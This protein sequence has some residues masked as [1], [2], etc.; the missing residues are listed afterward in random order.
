MG[1]EAGK[2]V[3]TVYQ[4]GSYVSIPYVGKEVAIKALY[5]NKGA[6]HVSIPIIKE[7]KRRQSSKRS[8]DIWVRKLLWS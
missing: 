2:D 7:R 1:K 6:V 5:A 3:K 4:V 8:E